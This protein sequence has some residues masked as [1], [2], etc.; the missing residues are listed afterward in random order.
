MRRTLVAR[1]TVAALAIAFAQVAQAQTA[2]TQT[3]Q[4][5]AGIEDIVVTARRSS[6]S[7]QS[8]PVAITALSGAMLDRQN[9]NDATALPALA[10]SLV[11]SQQPG[12]LS[13]AAVFIRGIG[14]QEPSAVAE[15]GV[16]L[17]GLV[18]AG[19]A[20]CS[21]QAARRGIASIEEREGAARQA[22]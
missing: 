8:V 10:P 12:S 13:A 11:M 9:V 20:V 18:C 22:A 17:A 6:E 4:D 15:Q 21:V 19:Y 2:D 1:G 3:A 14:N 5:G 7:M 16:G